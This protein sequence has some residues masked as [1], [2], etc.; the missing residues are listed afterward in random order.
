MEKFGNCTKI[1]RFIR[2][3]NI[4]RK[5]NITFYNLNVNIGRFFQLQKVGLINIFLFTIN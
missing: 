4:S 2:H 3:V 5:L 1:H